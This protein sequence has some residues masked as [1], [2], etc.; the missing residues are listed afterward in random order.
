MFLFYYENCHAIL[1]K[2]G[3]ML[4]SLALTRLAVT[5]CITSLSFSGVFMSELHVAASFSQLK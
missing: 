5:S 1:T 4:V 2:A 3:F